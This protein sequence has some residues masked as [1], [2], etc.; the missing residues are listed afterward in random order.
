LF[1]DATFEDWDG[2]TIRS[3]A[4][5]VE[6]MYATGLQ[7]HGGT[8]GTKHI[9]ANIQIEVDEDAGT[10]AAKSSYVV[11]QSTPRLHLQPIITGRYRDDFRR[12]ADGRW[13]FLVRRFAV[14]TK[15]DLTQHLDYAVPD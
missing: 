4:A 2:N 8:P 12:Y 14:D 13:Q 7:L 15:G 11:F 9:T 1:A 10:A 6:E 5:D 3:G